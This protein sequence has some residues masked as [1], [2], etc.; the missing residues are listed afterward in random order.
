MVVNSHEKPLSVVISSIMNDCRVF[1]L[2]WALNVDGKGM[3]ALSS[4]GIALTITM[5]QN[6]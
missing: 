5:V 4:L 3:M 1:L 2:K 6:I